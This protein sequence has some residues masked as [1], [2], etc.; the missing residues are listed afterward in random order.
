MERTVSY[1]SKWRRHDL[2]YCSTQWVSKLCTVPQ[3][4]TGRCYSY[5]KLMKLKGQFKN[6]QK[7]TMR[8]ITSL[9]LLKQNYRCPRYHKWFYVNQRVCKSD[10]WCPIFNP[11]YCH[12]SRLLSHHPCH[13]SFPDFLKADKNILHGGN[14]QSEIQDSKTNKK[15]LCASL[16]GLSINRIHTQRG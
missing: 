6:V 7:E 11:S 10:N 4:E 9:R 15:W 2:R 13:S 8:N 1:K 12:S 14:L 16:Q 5:T 3:N